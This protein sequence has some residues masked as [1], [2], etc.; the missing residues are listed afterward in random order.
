L[1]PGIFTKE[2][3]PLWRVPARRKNLAGFNG[4]FRFIKQK[5]ICAAA[6]KESRADVNNE[7]PRTKRKRL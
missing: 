2:G 3:Q 4:R 1:A 6:K 5:H 7:N